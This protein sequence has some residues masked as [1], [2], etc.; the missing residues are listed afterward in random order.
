MSTSRTF[1]RRFVSFFFSEVSPNYLKFERQLA[2]DDDDAI[3]QLDLAFGGMVPDGN[4]T[5][6]RSA[7]QSVGMERMT[8]IE[9]SLQSQLVVNPG[10]TVRIIFDVT[11]MGDQIM[12]HNFQVTGERA[13]LVN[14]GPRR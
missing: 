6:I 13:W 1:K 7:R 9:P 2:V 11:N 5:T 4:G 14:F 3:E 10:S 8:L 12:Y